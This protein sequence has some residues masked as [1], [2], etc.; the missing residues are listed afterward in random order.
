MYGQKN[1]LVFTDLDGTLLDYH[2][3][4]LQAA[5][6]ALNLFRENHIPLIVS[7]S[8]TRA[9][10]EPMLDLPAM[11]DV[12]IVENGSAVFFRRSLGLDPGEAAT[13]FG[14]YDVLILGQRY[15]RI[16]EVIHGAEERCGIKIRGFSR[17]SAVEIAAATGLDTA[18]AVRAK[19]REFSEPFVFEGDCSRF[20]EFISVLEDHGLTCTA[21]GRFHH[22]LGPCDKGMA[23][24]K[25]A[26]IYKRNYPATHWKTICLGDS[27]NDISMLKAADVAVIIRRH[28]GSFMEYVPDH[29][30]E[31]VRPSGIGPAGWNEAM[32]SLAGGAEE[33]G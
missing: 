12:F 27:A 30:Q 10:I 19:Q 18:S 11:S 21:G 7:S 6:P 20:F 13:P 5:M 28:D 3:Y 9:E 33:P 16:L 24:K 22:V 8:K 25:V 26:A 15:D 2:T 23:I 29:D 14:D 32:L 17:M 4:S 1:L 31:V